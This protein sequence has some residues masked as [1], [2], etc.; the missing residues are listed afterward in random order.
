MMKNVFDLFKL[1]EKSPVATSLRDFWNVNKMTEDGVL[2][3]DKAIG[4]MFEIGGLDGSF[5]S[6][7]QRMSLHTDWRSLLRLSSD[8]EIQ[9]VFR[10]RV[11]F[12][13][14]IED[15]V[16]QAFL[17]ENSYGRRILLERLADQVS[18]MDQDQPKLLSQKTILTFWTRE[19]LDLE[20]VEEKRQLV[21]SQLRSFGFYAQSLT[22]NQII[23]EI[24]SSAQDLSVTELQEP[25]WPYLKIEAGQIQVNGDIFR[26]L[27]MTQLPESYSEMGMIQAITDLP[28]PIDLC[29]R[30]KGKDSRPIISR[31]ERK[32]N[33]LNAQRSNKSSPSPQIESQ[34]EQ[35]DQVLR[36]LAD[37]SE[38]IFEM[39]MT[40][41]MRFPQHLASLHRKSLANLMRV[42]SQMDFCD[43]DEVSLGTFDAYLECIPGFTGKN[44]RT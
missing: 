32:R 31:L 2:Y 18:Q 24:N 38:S 42:G 25:E 30:I 11:E 36:D 4:F 17:S 37:R 27:E 5:L 23:S 9:I 35:I 7:D 40:L 15:Q 10:K 29:L 19:K 43:F 20:A 1:A 22:K 44:L 28:Y 41:G 21:E 39:T 8:E 26:G 12:A 14:W 34:M 16:A 3:S 33:L 6:S 13:Q